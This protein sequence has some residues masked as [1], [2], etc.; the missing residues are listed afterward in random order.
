[1]TLPYRGPGQATLAC[2]ERIDGAQALEQAGTVSVLK[3]ARA[4]TMASLARRRGRSGLIARLIG[5]SP[6][7]TDAVLRR[8]ARPDPLDLPPGYEAVDLFIL[9]WIAAEALRSRRN[10]LPL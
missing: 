2:H 6:I 9:Q 3:P 5:R 8:A 10:C 1:M 4:I 7:M